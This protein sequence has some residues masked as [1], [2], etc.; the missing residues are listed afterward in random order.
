MEFPQ[1]ADTA[2]DQS[3]HARKCHQDDRFSFVAV[4]SS[5]ADEAL[6]KLP[7][8]KIEIHGRFSLVRPVGDV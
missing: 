4:T 8:V 5:L 6:D 3:C 2:V 7:T 1:W